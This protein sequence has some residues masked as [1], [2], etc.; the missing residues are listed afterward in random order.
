MR[1]RTGTGRRRFAYRGTPRPPPERAGALWA[2]VAVATTL[3]LGA[4]I[5]LAVRRARPVVEVAP[6]SVAPFVDPSPAPAP[7]PETLETRWRR[8]AREAALGAEALTAS[9]ARALASSLLG[10]R[11]EPGRRSGADLVA[12]AAAVRDRV[13]AFERALRPDG[14]VLEVRPAGEVLLDLGPTGPRG[15]VVPGMRFRI[16][17]AGDGAPRGLVEAREVGPSGVLAS[18]VAGTAEGPIAPGDPALNPLASPGE[19]PRLRLSRRLPAADAADLAGLAARAGG[20]GSAEEASPTARVEPGETL[21]AA[22]DG[23]AATPDEVR[24]YLGGGI[25]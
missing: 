4:G 7:V 25:R 6:P 24:L 19:P 17:G 1:L 3:A 15:W 16:E 8:Q 23:L 14:R 11:R 21:A 10:P 5:V 18:P 9:A 2:A 12:S 22:P 20:R 13:G